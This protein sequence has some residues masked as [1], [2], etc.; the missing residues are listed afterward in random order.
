MRRAFLLFCFL[1]I[2]C[3]G[4][5]VSLTNAKDRDEAIQTKA[6]S[7]ALLVPVLSC[8]AKWGING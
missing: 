6:Q 7:A 1:T 8:I 3:N 2:M 5:A 4:Y